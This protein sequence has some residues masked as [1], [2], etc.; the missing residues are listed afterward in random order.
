MLP[1]AVWTM[2]SARGWAALAEELQALTG[3]DLE[4][5]QPGGLTMSFDEATLQA[6]AAKL[7]LLGERLGIKYPYEVLDPDS[8]RKLTPDIGP[9]VAGA[10]YCPLDGHVS[11]LRLLRSLINGFLLRGG[12]L[13]P[14]VHIEHL[15]YRNGEFH[16][17]TDK[18]LHV[19][20]RIVLTAGLGNSVLAPQV[21]LNAPVRP[22]RGQIFGHRAHAAV[23]AQSLS[24]CAPDRRGGGAD[25]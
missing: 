10:I 1:Y 17:H 16:V 6:S 23:P 8:L 24:L 14:G 7:N 20:Q 13:K 22:Q 2:E 3:I 11:P 12:D 19:A 18:G 5:L 4:L 9:D 21:G 15:E 25:R